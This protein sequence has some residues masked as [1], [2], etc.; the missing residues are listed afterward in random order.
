VSHFYYLGAT[1]PFLQFGAEAPFSRQAFLEL[2]GRFL[3]AETLSLLD[4]LALLSSLPP[5]S[6]TPYLAASY[7]A[8]ERGVRIELARLRAK[9]L[10]LA[11]PKVGVEG[12]RLDGVTAR[13]A[14]AA[15][16]AGSPLEGELVLEKARWDF[17]DSLSPFQGFD[18]D[19]L[20]AYFLKLLILERLAAL[21]TERGEAGYRRVYA[22]IM[23]SWRAGDSAGGA[24]GGARPSSA[25]A[26]AF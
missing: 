11:E 16:Q 4:S 14:Q 2:C 24:A 6:S 17:I 22:D 9:K 18:L 19:S 7:S 8:W 25:G 10:G 13:A 23:E 5:P 1:L 15:F 21:S 20:A 3:D 26:S 12:A